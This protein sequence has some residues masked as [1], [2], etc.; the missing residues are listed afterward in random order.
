M[1]EVKNKL[2]Q[3]QK[4]AF[5]III[6]IALLACLKAAAGFLTGS[7]ILLSD[8]IHSASD[9]LAIFASW[10][11]LKIAQKK[12]DKKFPY[13]YYKA[14]NL[15]T[16]FVSFIILWAGIN[17]A[18]EGYAKL[19]E[20]P[21]LKLAPL[22]L[23]A[24]GISILVDFFSSNYLKT[25]GKKINSQ[26][27]LTNAADKKNDIFV[28]GLVFISIF[29]SY[30]QIPYIEGLAT[31][32]IS[33]LILKVG[34]SSLKNSVL[35]LMDVSPGREIEE[36]VEKAIES[37]EGIECFSDLKLRKSGPFVF[38]SAKVGVRKYL[39]VQRAH[40]LADKI[41]K[42]I[43][44]KIPQINSFI[45]HIEPYISDYQHLVIPV[46]T[47]DQLKSPIYPK[48]AR[49]PYFLFVNLKKNKIIGFYFLK[50]PYQKLKVKAGLSVAKMIIKQ[51]SDTLITPQIGEI[52]MIALKNNLVD[53]YLAKEKN[54][55]Q[56]I[57]NYN[58]G[59]LEKK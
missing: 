20:V 23:A 43:K 7:M 21:V 56:A 37:V 4:A 48:F 42:E 13:G 25:A 46:K 34:L 19:F 47:E 53:I 44:Q 57:K 52:A 12:P 24:A 3:G 8:A 1:A 51:K 49:A 16:A 11:G 41:E 5:I 17:F 33:L 54:A 59:K 6:A 39:D 31:I 50:N 45:V 32:L 2:Q 55:E 10:A 15:A 28:S 9:I 14:E 26:A 36:K 27:L 18:R 29:L 40:Q 35:A 30:R 38:G 58:Q 22:A